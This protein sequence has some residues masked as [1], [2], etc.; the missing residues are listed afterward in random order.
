MV[1]HWH[2]IDR[3]LTGFNLP[4]CTFPVVVSGA[5]GKN[6]RGSNDHKGKQLSSESVP[7]TKSP[8]IGIHKGSILDALILSV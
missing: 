8:L 3:V 5:K 1:K 7:V 2:C 4:S 6:L